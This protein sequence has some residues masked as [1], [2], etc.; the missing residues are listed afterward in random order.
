MAMKGNTQ[1]PT[2]TIGPLSMGPMKQPTHQG[3]LHNYLGPHKQVFPTGF[4]SHKPN[5]SSKERE[6][7][8][9]IN[10]QD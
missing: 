9:N 10:L 2:G 3:S 4:T 5:L 1:I 7:Q 8:G 6:P